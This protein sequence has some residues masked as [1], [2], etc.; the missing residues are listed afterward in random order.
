MIGNCIL[1][2]KFDKLNLL[3]LDNLN[4]ADKFKYVFNTNL[5][6]I[7]VWKMVILWISKSPKRISSKFSFFYSSLFSISTW[8]FTKKI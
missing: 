6:K 5:I 7:E 8:R 2:I 3:N 4:V 1:N